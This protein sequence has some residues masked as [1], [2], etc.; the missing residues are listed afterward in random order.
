MVA[1]R[2]NALFQGLTPVQTTCEQRQ[3]G[4]KLICEMMSAAG[5]TSVHDAGCSKDAAV[6]YQDAYHAGEMRFRVYM[7]LRGDIFQSTKEAGLYT[8]LG[9][10]CLR[11]KPLRETVPGSR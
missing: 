7:M 11:P 5:L 6:A 10:E 8:G 4:V 2:A 3:A 1:E 9:D